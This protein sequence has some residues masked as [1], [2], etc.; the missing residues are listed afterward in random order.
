MFKVQNHPLIWD[1]GERR[2]LA[3][4][5]QGKKDNID[6]DLGRNQSM[7]DAQYFD[8]LETGS[9]ISIINPGFEIM[10]GQALEECD[11]D[12]PDIHPRP[13][14][15]EVVQMEEAC[16]SG[17]LTAVEAVFRS[18][19]LE[20]SEDERLDKARFA[21]SFKIAMTHDYIPVA[22]YLLSIGI[23]LNIA[24]FT[25]ALG[26]KAYSFLQLFLD[27]G[28]DINAQMSWAEPGP[29]V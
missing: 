29:L 14:S 22:S 17:D 16:A 20:K 27:Y 8:L 4:M 15:A 21:S 23:S 6:E 24:H 28:F 1:G 9:D 10:G 7:I 5:V 18:Q 13:P 19:W 12:D 3:E 26:M 2:L 25:R 11:P